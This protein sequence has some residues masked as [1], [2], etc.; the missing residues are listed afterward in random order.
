MYHLVK[1]QRRYRYFNAWR[2]SP[3][4]ADKLEEF[5]DDVIWRLYIWH[6]HDFM[7]Y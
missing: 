3:V 2:S 7:C 5:V 1:Y 6:V 4:A